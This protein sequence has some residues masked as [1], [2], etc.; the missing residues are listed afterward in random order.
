MW[1]Q[2]GWR[3]ARQEPALQRR[4]EQEHLHPVSRKAPRTGAAPAP[5]AASGALGGLPP[6][7]PAS[8]LPQGRQRELSLTFTGVQ[9]D[10]ARV[11]A[12]ADAGVMR[13]WHAASGT[14]DSP[15]CRTGDAQDG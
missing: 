8:A 15:A 3:E 6:A 9:P 10:L 5:A 14:A 4:L 11:H 1:S 13:R 2:A 7:A 12:P